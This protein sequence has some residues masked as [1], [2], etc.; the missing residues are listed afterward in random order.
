M[1][2]VSSKTYCIEM[3]PDGSGAQHEVDR[4]DLS[5]PVIVALGGLDASNIIAARN[6]AESRLGELLGQ[7]A[8][9]DSFNAY[10]LVYSGKEFEPANHPAL[11]ADFY[12]KGEKCHAA[13]V[14]DT[15]ARNWVEQYLAPEVVSVTGIDGGERTLA[16]EHT[17]DQ[18]GRLNFFA[19]SF[20]SLMLRHMHKQIDHMLTEKGYDADERATIMRRVKALNIGDLAYWRYD[21]SDWRFTS[22]HLTSHED[23]LIKPMTVGH[24]QD[25]KNEPVRIE[26]PADSMLVLH[27][28]LPKTATEIFLRGDGSVGVPRERTD[29]TGHSPGLHTRYRFSNSSGAMFTVAMLQSALRNM[30]NASAS[31]QTVATPDVLLNPAPQVDEVVD[32]LGNLPAYGYADRVNSLLGGVSARQTFVRR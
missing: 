10:T 25:F 17:S 20:G 15:L 30:L 26:R 32:C 27:A 21:A 14:A 5:H 24:V 18:M 3:R 8:Y 12:E 13:N 23:E 6:F 28:A 16:V 9:K 19:F 31:G 4:I 1:A 29:P 2:E 7:Q 11:I 22:L